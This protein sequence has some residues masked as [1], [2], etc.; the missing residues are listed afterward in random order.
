MRQRCP[1]AAIRDHRL[2]TRFWL[3][4]TAKRHAG[5][6][7][8]HLIS[9]G[10]FQGNEVLFAD[11]R[12]YLTASCERARELVAAYNWFAAHNGKEQIDPEGSNVYAPGRVEQ[13]LNQWVRLSRGK[14]LVATG[15]V[16]EGRD[17]ILSVLQPRK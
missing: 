5:P 11:A 3:L 12:E 8:D 1:I 14:A 15:K 9:Q 10:Y 13:L 17:E 4:G 2:T 6:F 16:F 7:Q